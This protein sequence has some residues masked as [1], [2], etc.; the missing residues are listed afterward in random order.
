M[1]LAHPRAIAGFFSGDDLNRLRFTR[2]HT[3]LADATVDKQIV[4]RAYTNNVAIQ[5]TEL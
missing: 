2:E 4:E 5:Q 1:G 3:P